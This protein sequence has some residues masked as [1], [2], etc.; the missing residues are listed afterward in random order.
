MTDCIWYISKYVSLPLKSRAGS[1]GY[2]IMKEIAKTGCKCIIITSD[3]NN[4]SDT[5]IFKSKY[6]IQKIDG[7]ILCWIHVIKYWKTK[8]IRRIFSW[9]DFELK[10]F[11]M[12]KSS[13]PRPNVIIVS[14]LSLITILNG[15]IL[16]AKYKSKLI[17]EIRDIWPLTI[18]E[19]GGFNKKNPFILILSL[20][21]KIGYRYSDMIVGT[22]PNLG[23]HVFEILGI[24][25]PVYCIP[26][27][28]NEDDIEKKENLPFDYI[29]KYIPKEKFIVAYLGSIGISNALNTLMKCI[30]SMKQL[31][32]IHFLI[33]GEGDLKTEYIKNYSHLKNLTF[34]PQIPKIMVQSALSYC[35]LL[36][37][38]VHN[39][40]VWK[41]GQSLNKVIDYMLAG[42]PIIASYTG[43]QTMINEALCG[44]YVPSGDVHSLRKEILRYA[45]MRIKDRVEIGNRG[46]DWIL[47]NRSYNII[48]NDYLSIINNSFFLEKNSK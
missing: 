16:R 6:L 25:K 15:F 3:S 20:I 2:F 40:K 17:F 43:Y 21:E 5:R 32:N 48:A 24:K 30:E 10:L 44:S 18:V 38:S 34:C 7:L 1:R 39:S 42:K 41:Y 36:Y 31:E 4:L 47:K 45:E 8:S 19:E 35:D 13:L 14:S 22:M 28:I 46:H 23:L 37:F 11:C 33:I 9:L 26:I 29:N 27:G 12:P